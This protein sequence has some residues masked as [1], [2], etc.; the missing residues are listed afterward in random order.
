MH[1]VRGLRQ[2]LLLQAAAGAV[3]AA[4]AGLWVATRGGGY[5]STFGITLMVLAGLV[6]VSGG[7]EL[8]RGSTTDARAFLGSGPDREEPSTG[9]ALT[10]V[11]VFLLV[12][13]PLF[14][15]GGF[16]RSGV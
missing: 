4:V 9:D 2:A 3:A 7:T 6:S 16:L 11:G 1:V 15:V 5:L 10:A 14:V 8:A 13:V 12:A